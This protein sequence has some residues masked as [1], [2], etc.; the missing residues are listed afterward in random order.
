LKSLQQTPICD[1]ARIRNQETFENI[2]A[3]GALLELRF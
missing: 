1:G 2:V 3:G